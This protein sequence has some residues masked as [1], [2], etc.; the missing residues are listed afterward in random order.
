MMPKVTLRATD[1]IGGTIHASKSGKNYEHDAD[2]IVIVDQ[3]DVVDLLATHER[4]PSERVQRDPNAPQVTAVSVTSTTEGASALNPADRM[5][6]TR[7][8]PNDDGQANQDHGGA[9]PPHGEPQSEASTDASR[10]DAQAE[11][12]AAARAGVDTEHR[13]AV[14][15]TGHMGTAHANEADQ[16]GARGGAQPTDVHDPAYAATFKGE[17][18]S[19]PK[20][21]GKTKAEVDAGKSA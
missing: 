13:S 16:A 11:V 7:E 6:N 2:G 17:A 12:D 3:E 1:G 14:A 9:I 21:R 15:D 18:D 10:A 20:L 5:K 4:V 8:V 19:D